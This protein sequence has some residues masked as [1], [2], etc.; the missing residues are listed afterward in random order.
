VS[1]N[2]AALLLAIKG[3]CRAKVYLSPL[4]ITGGPEKRVQ[5]GFSRHPHTGSSP[6]LFFKAGHSKAIARGDEIFLLWVVIIQKFFRTSLPG[7]PVG[8]Y[9]GIQFEV[10]FEKKKEKDFRLPGMDEN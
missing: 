8:E 3:G 1:R 6:G 7:T 5:Y 4:F 10:S 2:Q 9:V